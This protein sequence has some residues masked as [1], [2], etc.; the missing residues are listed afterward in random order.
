MSEVWLTILLSFQETSANFAVLRAVG[1]EESKDFCVV[2]NP[3]WIDLPTKLDHTV[4]I[5]WKQFGIFS[6]E[7]TA[8]KAFY[9][10]LLPKIFN[11]GG[12]LTCTSLVSLRLLLSNMYSMLASI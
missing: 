3:Q 12:A 11:E 8:V 1:S 10:S 9:F 5:C 2:Y 6:A 4:R 7:F